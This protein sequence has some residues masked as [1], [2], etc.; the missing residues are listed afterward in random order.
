M[1]RLL[2][3]VG[4]CLFEFT[5]PAAAQLPVPPVPV[6]G[7]SGGQRLPDD[8]VEGI[9]LEYQGVLDPA[10]K[11]QGDDN[12]L[13]GRV[14]LEKTAIYEISPLIKVPSLEEL[15]KV[16]NKL[17]SGKG[18]SVSLPPLP[19]QKRLGQFA[20][21]GGNKLRLDFDDKETLYGTMLLFKEKGTADVW[22][23]T[24][25]DRKDGK[26]GRVWKV[27]VRPVED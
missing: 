2:V 23:G 15:Q 8:Q 25:T 1:K 6:P 19:Q 3:F 16:L 20:K 22:V 21:T 14:R 5:T 7:A 9:I 27:K 10:S 26:T 11:S 24:Y 4:L 17:L 18:G 12:V 13:A